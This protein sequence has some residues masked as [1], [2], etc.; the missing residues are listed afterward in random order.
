M[1]SCD[2]QPGKAPQGGAEKQAGSKPLESEGRLDRSKA[3]SVAP[4]IEFEDP[5]GERVSLADF[6]GKPVLLNLWATWCAPCV[7]EMPTLD[8]LAAR[9]RDLQVLVVSEDFQG[10]DKVEAF[11]EQHRLSALEPYRDPQLGLMTDLNAAV[12]PTTIL[13]DGRGREVWRMTGAEDWEG[14]RA[15]ALLAEAA[16]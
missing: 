12:L 15:R 6:A 3:G 10:R 14:Q 7:A 16:R 1:A 5:S 9:E 2:A 13:Y 4:D 8:R 11:F